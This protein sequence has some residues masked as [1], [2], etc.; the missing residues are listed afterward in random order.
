[1]SFP[2]AQGVEGDLGLSTDTYGFEEGAEYQ[3][4]G[5][6]LDWRGF[7]GFWGRGNDRDRYERRKRVAY[8]TNEAFSE[9]DEGGSD[10]DDFIEDDDEAHGE[11]GSPPREEGPRCTT[12]V[13]RIESDD[14][15][16]DDG[17]GKGDLSSCRH[18]KKKLRR[19]SQPDRNGT[20]EEEE[21]EEGEK[22]TT[23]DRKKETF[24]KGSMERRVIGQSSDDDDE[25][26]QPSTKKQ[27]RL[28]RGSDETRHRRSSEA[29]EKRREALQR[30]SQARKSPKKR[31]EDKLREAANDDDHDEDDDGNVEELGH[32]DEGF[33]IPD[34]PS[35]DDNADEGDHEDDDQCGQSDLHGPSP[36][37][38]ALK[39]DID[40]ERIERRAKRGS[41]D[42]KSDLLRRAAEH[43][44]VKSVR[45]LIGSGHVSTEAA[46]NALDRL[47]VLGNAGECAR[48]LV[49]KANPAKWRGDSGETLL[50]RAAVGPDAQGV[51]LIASEAPK[52]MLRARDAKGATPLMLAAGSGRSDCLRA[53][54]DLLGTQARAAMAD[55]DEDRLTAAHYAAHF[56]SLEVL[57]EL[58]RREPA[59]GVARDEQG[60]TP[61]HHAALQGQE[62]AIHVLLENGTPATITDAGGFPPLLY[63]DFTGE[64]RAVLALL[65]HSLGDQLEE[66][67]RLLKDRGARDKCLSALRHLAEVPEYCE[68]LNDFLRPRPELLSTGL[69]YL[70]SKPSILT[71]QTRQAWLRHEVSRL[72]RPFMH[73]NDVFGEFHLSSTLPFDHLHEAAQRGGKCFF[74]CVPSRGACPLSLGPVSTFR[75]MAKTPASNAGTGCTI[76]SAS[77]KS[78]RLP[79]L[80]WNERPLRGFSAMPLSAK[81]LLKRPQGMDATHSRWRTQ[82][83]RRQPHLATSWHM[84]FST[85]VALPLNS[86]SQ[87]VLWGCESVASFAQDVQLPITLAPSLLRALQCRQGT[88]E[89]LEAEDP[90]LFRSLG[91]LEET[92]GVE[93]LCLTF[94]AA[95]GTELRP[96]GADIAV[97]D[98][99][100]VDY[101]KRMTHHKLDKLN[102]WLASPSPS[103]FASAAHELIPY[104]ILRPF[105]PGEMTLL[106]SALTSISAHLLW[107]CNVKAVTKEI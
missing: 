5:A 16:D 61:L 30:L 41:P 62:G 20:G 15:D 64:R 93:G 98:K 52:G 47:L 2:P 65:D 54:L 40:P 77:W 14:D 71:F 12:G 68:A 22:E 34:E 32:D 23:K 60:A 42:E 51:H 63:A 90:Q 69:S 24:E 95:D 29:R 102:S 72:P 67:G 21:E 25:E 11:D 4:T 46:G 96:G 18:R 86:T 19:L 76:G 35:D 78:R 94:Q 66:M 74:M 17:D 48:L 80:G 75:L 58:L 83:K 43:G 50:H 28:R 103:S 97:T 88:L 105:C 73:A 44:A 8:T 3:T 45:A 89:D 33:I 27:R 1:M 36:V 100:K 31:L 84:P 49:G 13:P 10:L 87:T 7:W 85:C 79:G 56:G 38:R 26:E 55:C 107:P 59:C 6:G 92:V 9:E 106:I 53:L 99:N 91:K 57:H 70:L 37:E 104:R 101:C 82:M 81:S 39:N